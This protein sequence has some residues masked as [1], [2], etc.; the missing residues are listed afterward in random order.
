[1]PD[2]EVR[3]LRGFIPI[4][5]IGSVQLANEAINK[6]KQYN[7]SLRGANPLQHWK[8]SKTGN[9]ITNWEG[10]VGQPARNVANDNAKFNLVGL[11]TNLL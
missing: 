1:M 2:P 9:R 6:L 7:I 11:L 5:P 8:K 10:A 4:I 3:S